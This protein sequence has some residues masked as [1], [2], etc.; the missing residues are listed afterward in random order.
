MYD[1]HFIG[2][3]IFNLYENNNKENKMCCFMNNLT[4]LANNCSLFMI[5]LFPSLCPCT[6]VFWRFYNLI[7]LDIYILSVR[8]GAVSLTVYFQV[9]MNI[10]H[11]LE[12]DSLKSTL[13]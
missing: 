11:D 1:R 10:F 4:T 5:F 7:Y 12:K 3:F 9:K 13:K 6:Y 2:S 8:M